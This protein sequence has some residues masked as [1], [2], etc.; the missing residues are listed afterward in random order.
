MGKTGSAQSETIPIGKIV[1]FHG[2]K[3]IV[4]VL[5]YAESPLIFE[6][7]KS[8]PLRKP[9][10]ETVVCKILSA[11]PHKRVILM[12]LEDVTD[13]NEAEKLADAEFL[14]DKSEFPETE[15]DTYYWA[16][17]IGLS[18]FDADRYIGKI[19]SILETGSNDVYVVKDRDHEV[20]IPALASVVIHVDPENGIMKV[21]LP[22]GL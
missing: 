21:D 20:L 4:K 11:K 8:L 16:D 13:R 22:E 19:D 6:A 15:E 10:G 9:N 12:A 18:V 17:L 14:I 7:G 1:G 5:S 3:G 2:L